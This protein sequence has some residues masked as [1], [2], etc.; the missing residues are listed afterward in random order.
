[1]IA[2]LFL[3]TAGGSPALPPWLKNALPWLWSDDSISKHIR[4]GSV[5]TYCLPAE[6][7]HFAR[8]SECR[9]DQGTQGER[10][11]FEFETARLRQLRETA[12]T[13]GPPIWA[14]GAYLRRE[15]PD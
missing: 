11:G 4:Y 2:L 13:A 15:T 12:R 6:F 1:M 10:Y 14:A 3:T 7:G 9:R 5:L 8:A